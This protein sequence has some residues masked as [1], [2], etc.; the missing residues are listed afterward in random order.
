MLIFA[1]TGIAMHNN[2]IDLLY[3]LPKYFDSDQQKTTTLHTDFSFHLLITAYTT[4]TST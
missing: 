4:S 2:N 1:Y 3:K